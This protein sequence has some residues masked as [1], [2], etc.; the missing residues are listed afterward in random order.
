MLNSE[1]NSRGLNFS[2]TVNN[3]QISVYN[4]RNFDLKKKNKSI[5]TGTKQTNIQALHKWI[6]FFLQNK[7]ILNYMYNSA[8]SFIKS[9]EI[10]SLSYSK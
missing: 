2:V 6:F 1:I 9:C 5:K 8:N 10:M 4:S 7:Q 3:E